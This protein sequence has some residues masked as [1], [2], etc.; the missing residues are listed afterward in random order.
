ML[1]LRHFRKIE[2]EIKGLKKCQSIYS[3]KKNALCYKL[4]KMGTQHRANAIERMIRDY[5]ITMGNRVDYFGGNHSY[6]MVVNGKKVEVKSS[7][8]Q[9]I[10]GKKYR[11]R[12]QNIKSG[13]FHEIILVF[14]TPKGIKIKRMNKNRLENQIR[15][16]KCYSNG[17]TLELKEL[18]A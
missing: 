4:S 14:V 8:A 5:L 7:L 17:K 11:Y 10:S 3:R 18:A 9:P 12:F 16:A 13:Y 15:Y 2:K 6:D 1:T